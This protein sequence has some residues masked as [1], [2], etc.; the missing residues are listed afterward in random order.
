MQPVV[1]DDL[2]FQVDKFIFK[3]WVDSAGDYVI[4]VYNLI[5]TWA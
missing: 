3:I 4:N 1:G 2:G 5:F